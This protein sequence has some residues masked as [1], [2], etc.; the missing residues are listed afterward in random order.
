V[1]S[2]P[3]PARASYSQLFSDLAKDET[4]PAL[5]HCTAGKDH[6]GWGAAAL[7]LILGVVEDVVMDDYLMSNRYILPAYQMVME[8]FT[9]QGGDAKLLEPVL[10]VAPAY[11]EAALAQVRA[12]YGE[13]AGYFREGLGLD[14]A[15]V[16]GLRTRLLTTP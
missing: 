5:W 14:D 4:G 16:A 6:T 8:T 9:A 1:N 11:L 12:D 7:L 15:T 10:G 2:L 13:I 3:C